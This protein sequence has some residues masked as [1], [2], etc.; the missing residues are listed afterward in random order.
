MSFFDK[1]KAFMSSVEDFLMPFIK[2]FL[3]TEG[4]IVLAAAEK[5]VVAL[6]AQ[7][8]PGAQKQTAAFAAIVTDLQGQGVTA[9]A[10]VINSAIEVSVAKL[11]AP[12]S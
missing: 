10:S 1:F 12:A 9:A 4:P 8:M 11:N 5:A 7:S 2:Q 6:A 3:T